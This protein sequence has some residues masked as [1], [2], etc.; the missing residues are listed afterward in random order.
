[1]LPRERV[2]LALSHREADRIPI[3]DSVWNTTEQRWKKEG[4]P[5][6][7]H[8]HEYFQYEMAFSRG[9][10]SL[11]LPV[12]VLEDTEDYNVCRD[13]NGTVRKNFKNQTSTPHIMDYLV[14]SEEKWQELKPL[15]AMNDLRLNLSRIPGDRDAY[16]RGLFTVFATA[17][18]YE[19]AKDLVGSENLLMQMA[20]NPGWVKDM[21]MTSVDLTINLAEEMMHRGGY[22]FNGAFLYDD[23]GYTKSSFFSPSMYRELL[24]PWHKRICDFFHGRKMPVILHS[25]GNIKGLIPMLIEAGFDCLQPLQARAGMDVLELKKEY[26]D[27]LS[28]MG[29]INVALMEHPDSK[30]IETEIRTKISLA[31]KG[32]GYIYHSDHSIPDDVSFDRYKR[33]MELVHECGVYR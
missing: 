18:G 9:D 20:M 4:L 22:L 12:R 5:E 33:V 10:N 8:A 31:K 11:L 24:L 27:K 2:M 16:G 28:F 23:L 17:V 7:M 25:C 1:M 14:S 3:H 19:W 30:L 15:L 13:A 6:N 29:N 21:F 26:G 32:G